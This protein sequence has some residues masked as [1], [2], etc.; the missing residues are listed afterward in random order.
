LAAQWGAVCG[1]ASAS[2]L[3]RQRGE[4]GVVAAGHG[5]EGLQGLVEELRLC[6]R[7]REPTLALVGAFRMVILGV[8]G[9][10]DARPV[11]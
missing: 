2:Q 3:E 6:A 11:T 1:A 4:A 9:V 8:V 5:D 10:L 7:A